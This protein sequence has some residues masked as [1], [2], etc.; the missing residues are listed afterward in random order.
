MVAQALAAGVQ[1]AN[2]RRI[3]AMSDNW[4]LTRDIQY[5]I[6]RAPNSKRV[7][8]DDPGKAVTGDRRALEALQLD[9]PARRSTA[10]WS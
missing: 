3:G 8:P 2:R 4:G 1:G 9:G 10:A 6:W 5:A 7:L